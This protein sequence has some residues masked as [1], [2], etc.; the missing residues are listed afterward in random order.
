MSSSCKRIILRFFKIISVIILSS[1]VVAFRIDNYEVGKVFFL[2]NNLIILLP[3]FS[4][5]IF[6]IIN[7][8]IAG[9]FYIITYREFRGLA[10]F[11]GY[12]PV[13]FYLD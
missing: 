4:V 1:V 10:I 6:E 9:R 3:Y 7:G 11:L 8:S 12:N 2:A 13:A 5:E